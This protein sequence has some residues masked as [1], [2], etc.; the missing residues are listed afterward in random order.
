MKP[1]EKKKN[2]TAHNKTW[3]QKIKAMQMNWKY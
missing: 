2:K 3:K 1:A